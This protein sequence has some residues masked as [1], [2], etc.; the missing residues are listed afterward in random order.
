MIGIICAMQ[1][2]IASL[3][4]HMK[5]ITEEKYNDQVFYVGKIKKEDVVLSVC[6]VGKTFSTICTQ[7][8]IFKYMPDEIINLGVAGG[9]DKKINILDTVIATKVCQHDFDTSALGDP[10]GTFTSINRMYFNCSRK[11][12]DKIVAAAEKTG[13]KSLKGI[14]ASGDQFIASEEKKEYLRKTFKASAC[15]MEAGAIGMTCYLA[16]V[17]FAVIRSI[18]DGGNDDAKMDF[19]VF[20]KKAVKNGTCILL[21]YLEN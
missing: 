12:V 6:G 11:M 14:V 2:E 17:P 9:I 7:T 20:L 8:M 3:K 5:N 13:L 21:S 19:P 18:S 16:K 4:K 1:D 10:V 15:D